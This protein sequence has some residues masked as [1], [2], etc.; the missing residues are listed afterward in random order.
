MLSKNQVDIYKTDL[1]KNHSMVKRLNSIK[2]YL[3]KRKNKEISR[4]IVDYFNQYENE[5]PGIKVVWNN[6]STEKWYNIHFHYLHIYS[7]YVGDNSFSIE[8]EYFDIP[9]GK[10]EVTNAINFVNDKF[11]TYD[12]TGYIKIPNVGNVKHK[13]ISA[14]YDNYFSVIDSRINLL[15]NGIASILKE[16]IN[17]IN[18]INSTIGT[19]YL[20]KRVRRDGEIPVFCLIR[21]NKLITE[22]L[23]G[24]EPK[25]DDI[26]INKIK[27]LSTTSKM[28]EVEMVSDTNVV[29]KKR[30]KKETLSE[31]ILPNSSWYKWDNDSNDLL[32]IA[33]KYWN[34]SHKHK[35]DD[36]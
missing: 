23:F 25:K 32:N 12:E 10:D 26:K 1:E 33:D 21:K 36:Y 19:T 30:I 13:E 5:Y 24:I 2:N 29:Y 17:D 31:N 35:I 15:E 9:F 6:V 14:K 3:R 20:A 7:I 8:R 16:F 11:K 18:V 22:Y 27:I 4:N 28:V 34:V